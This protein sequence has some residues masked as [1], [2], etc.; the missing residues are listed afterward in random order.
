MGDHKTLFIPPPSRIH[1]GSAIGM[2]GDF[3]SFPQGTI[4]HVKV[5]GFIYFIA[6][7]LALAPFIFFGIGERSNIFSQAA[8][9]FFNPDELFKVLKEN[10][11]VPVPVGKKVDLAPVEDLFKNQVNIT[12]QLN[13]KLGEGTSID[14]VDFFKRLLKILTAFLDALTS[15]FETF[16]RLMGS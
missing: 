4:P 9:N 16:S 3:K 2:K 11:A 10:I 7:V 13:E 5:M 14:F 12:P 1:R 8:L 15:F 6:V